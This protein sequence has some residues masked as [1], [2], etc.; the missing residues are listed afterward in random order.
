MSV[1]YYRKYYSADILLYMCTFTSDEG[2][3]ILNME[4][5]EGYPLSCD[6]ELYVHDDNNMEIAVVI[7]II[8]YLF[9]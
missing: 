9:I 7:M 1:N 2:V 3:S 8:I 5:T 4:T 6:G